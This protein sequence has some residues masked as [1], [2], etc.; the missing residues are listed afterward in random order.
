MAA[1]LKARLTAAAVVLREHE[2][3][4]SFPTVS[5]FQCRA[6][7]DELSSAG[8]LLAAAQLA[9]IAT[10]TYAVPWAEDDRRAASLSLESLSDKSISLVRKRRT[11][12]KYL[13]FLDYL[14]QLTID[15]LN[16]ATVVNTSKL[17]VVSEAITKLY[18]VNPCEFTVKMAT[19]VYLLAAFGLREAVAMSPSDKH[20]AQLSMKAALK[21]K[22]RKI[23]VSD[24]LYVTEL[25]PVTELER[26]HPALYDAIASNRGSGLNAVEVAKVYDS[27]QCRLNRTSVSVSTTLACQ[28]GN[29]GEHGMQQHTMLD[30]MTHL[31]QLMNQQ[32][33]DAE[34]RDIPIRY[35]TPS[36]ESTEPKSSTGSE[37]R[38]RFVMGLPRRLEPQDAGC[39][40]RCQTV[41]V[42]DDSLPAE[43][44]ST[45]PPAAASV[46]LAVPPAA[47]SVVKT[48]LAIQVAD[49]PEAE[50]VKSEDVPPVVEVSLAIP[51]KAS[52]A[53]SDGKSSS[54]KL[55]AAMMTTDKKKKNAASMG[56]LPSGD[57]AA[58]AAD[59]RGSPPVTRKRLNCKTA[60]NAVETPSKI[61][62]PCEKG[63]P[64]LQMGES[65]AQ[66]VGSIP[67][68][69]LMPISHGVNVMVLAPDIPCNFNSM[70]TIV[71]AIGVV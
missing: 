21:R 40:R 56:S 2:S 50:P 65:H 27:F 15:I 67:N 43:P 37:E 10:M 59:G 31:M 19:S 29:N 48:P 57:R 52:R 11:S 51:E 66:P 42:G 53:E 5:R 30:C 14:P 62:K 39:L 33:R 35:I 68:V 38:L 70:K 22:S 44:P 28:G 58:G 32:R 61:Q 26:K 23:E 54:L 13:C 47:A 18:C 6:F 41:N 16:D 8:K 71:H 46:V 17:E 1:A 24:D 3:L 20:R 45:E 34:P 49:N 64:F 9:D 12:Q 69:F 60:V 7:I 36:S 4:P 55:L 25:F 63:T